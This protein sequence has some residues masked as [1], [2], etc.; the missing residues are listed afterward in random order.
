[1]A[2]DSERAWR[3]GL[4][5]VALIVAGSGWYQAVKIPPYYLADEQAHVGYVLELEQGRLPEVDTPID[6]DRGGVALRDKLAISPERNRDVWVAN[7]PPWPYVVA[8]PAAAATSA[9]GISGGPLLGVRIVNLAFFA[10]AA[11]ALARLARRLAGDDPTAGLLAAGLFA[12]VP[13]VGLIAG[14]AFVDGA[15]LLCTIAVTDAVVA[16]T[17]SGPTRRQVVTLS[18]WCAL[19]TGVRP[20]TAV[21][22]AAAAGIALAVV[23]LR[24]WR[25]R[26]AVPPWWAGVVLAVPSVVL[27]GWTYARNQALYGD[28]TASSRLFEKYGRTARPRAD[29]LQSKVWADPVRTLLNRRIP[30]DLPSP[31]L[32]VWDLTRWALVGFAVASVVIVIGDQV[33][34]RRRGEQEPRTPLLG[35]ACTALGAVVIVVLTAQHWTGGGNI[36]P[37][38]LLFPLAV[39]AM[40]VALPLARA[41]AWWAGIALVA[42]VLA[43]QARQ[44][45]RQNAY[46]FTPPWMPEPPSPLVTA[47][48]PPLL[49]TLGVVAAAAGFVLF[50]VAVAAVAAVQRADTTREDG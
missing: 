10:A 11:V 21:L 22:A 41:R 46:L 16:I 7:N 30:R 4:V 20:M 50:V 33:T 31:P 23:A 40:L 9:L 34:A 15:A 18:I 47:I 32:W 27:S 49:R 39:A 19:A 13:H 17:R 1:M 26:S 37:R 5:A 45:P 24:W 2:R 42:A 25:D 36:H 14:A 29:V 43:L 38:Y 3:L 28:P 48:G 35:W 6:G 8:L 44:V 12:A